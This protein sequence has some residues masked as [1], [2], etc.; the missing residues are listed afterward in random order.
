MEIFLYIIGGL[1][2]GLLLYILFVPKKTEIQLP[3]VPAGHTLFHFLKKITL[4]GG[5]NSS[6]LTGFT[7]SIEQDIGSH[8]I[9]V[10]HTPNQQGN[11]TVDL[12]NGDTSVIMNTKDNGVS[13]ERMAPPP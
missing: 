11:F 4:V 8:L 7:G 9:G 2:L 13:W 1:L 5:S 3:I 6:S 10:E 12:D